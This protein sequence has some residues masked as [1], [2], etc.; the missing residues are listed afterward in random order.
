MIECYKTSAG[1]T[2]IIEAPEPGCWVN[3][4]SP[5]SDER[6]WLR[7]ELGIEPEFV[8]ATLDD[9]ERS[10]VD[11]DDDSR[12]TLVI[13]DCPSIEDAAD[14]K[15]PDIVQYDTHPL[16]FLFLPEQD[17]LVTVALRHNLTIDAFVENRLQRINTNQRTRL[18]LMMLLNV[19]HQY[20][21]YLRNLNR[22]FTRVERELR[23][24]MRNNDLIKMLGFQNSLV[25][26]SISLK[27]DETML[28]RIQKGRV[29]KMY[30][31]DQDLLEDVQIEFR[32]AIEMC[33]INTS[34]L[35]GTMDT[36]SSVINNNMNQVMRRLTLI[37][38]MMAIPTIVFSFYGMNIEGLPG[39]CS[40]IIPIIVAI[41]AC[42]VAGIIIHRSKALK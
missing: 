32:Q 27:A 42:I 5:T 41:V 38:L 36:F 21:I 14:T 8:N 6:E 23:Q 22:Q 39:V 7:N 40:W 17:M 16:S 24:S 33:T 13:V 34:I 4:V 20:Q 31:E 12:Q 26:F 11:Y 9:E 25:Y 19:A 2:Q 3:V 30:E 10:H 35:E 37:T 18:L 29:I 1:V 15:S 28:Q